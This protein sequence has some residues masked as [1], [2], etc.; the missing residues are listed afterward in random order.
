MALRHDDLA[1]LV[2]GAEEHNREKKVKKVRQAWFGL[3]A[4]DLREVDDDLKLVLNE[5]N[6]K[7]ELQVL[8]TRPGVWVVL[9]AQYTAVG[10]NADDFQQLVQRR[11][12]RVKDEHVAIQTA[13]IIP[14]GA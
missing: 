14:V 5:R 11:Y 13:S 8:Q 6:P 7:W 4:V 9:N 2:R 3:C 1:E 12:P 10:A